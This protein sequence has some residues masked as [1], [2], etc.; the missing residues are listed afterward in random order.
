VGPTLFGARLLAPSEGRLQELDTS[1]QVVGVT[2]SIGGGM[3]EPAI[4]PDGTLYVVHPQ[5]IG[6]E[7]FQDI[8]TSLWQQYGFRSVKREYGGP[9]FAFGGG[10]YTAAQDG[11]YALQLGPTGVTV[12]WRYPAPAPNSIAFV[13]APLI[14]SDG[15][16]YSWAT[17]SIGPPCSSELFAFWEDK[18]VEPNS[19]WPTWRHDARRSGQAH[20]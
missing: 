2:P 10:L 11:F 20:R 8:S 19:P 17:C 6:I 1:G 13:G 9:A 16:V 5:N 7:A 15:T 14:G 12:R 4:G 18:L 3:S